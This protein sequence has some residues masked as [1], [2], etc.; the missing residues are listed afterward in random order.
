MWHAWRRLAAVFALFWGAIG[1][2]WPAAEAPGAPAIKAT[3]V[4]L[5]DQGEVTRVAIDLSDRPAY[6]IFFLSQ[7]MRA[8]IDFPGLRWHLPAAAAAPGGLVAGYRT[9][10]FDPS[11]GRL[12]LDLAAPARLRAARFET[13]SSRRGERLVLDFEPSSLDAFLAEL[14]P[15]QLSGAKPEAPAATQVAGAAAPSVA[16][17]ARPAPPSGAKPEAP[18][19]TQV[20]GAAVPS[21]AAGARLAP[22][23]PA[24]RLI[25]IDPGHGG[26][27]P[28]AI[29][30]NGLFEKDLTLAVGREIR[31]QLEASGRY[32][33]VLTR[34]DDVFMRLRER[35]GKARTAGAELFISVHADTMANTQIRGASIYTLSEIA[36]DAEAAALAARE[37]RADV[38]GGVD[39]SQESKDVATILIDLAQRESMNL[40]AIFAG[41]LVAELAQDAQVLPTNPHRFAGFA[42]LKAPDI[43]SVL[44]ELGYLSNRQDEALLARPHYRTKVAAAVVRAIDQY[45]ARPGKRS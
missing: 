21:V 35:V 22:R 9:G 43:P 26:I 45:F 37:N 17:G 16:A 5:A 7:P 38:L 2:V 33:V 8:V 30:A 34:E 20:A 4:T 41:L 31:R 24:K 32:R 27:D 40:S 14:Q 18:A 28:G 42:V 23:A 13:V 19:A 10:A 3:A 1:G 25:A 12:V 39:L 15:P 6:R 11:T 44:L 36:S 29:G